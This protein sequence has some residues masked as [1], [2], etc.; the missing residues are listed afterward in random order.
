[1]YYS[2]WE[3]NSIKIY[4]YV[5]INNSFSE[6]VMLRICWSVVFVFVGSYGTSFVSDQVYNIH[7]YIYNIYYY[8][9]I[10]I[11]KWIRNSRDKSCII[12]L[13]NR[14]TIHLPFLS[15]KSIWFSLCFMFRFICWQNKSICTYILYIC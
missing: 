13:R 15:R 10:K 1:M 8:S 3:T 11:D 5:I 14:Y 7:I 6:N 4:N 9:N 2:E 12:R